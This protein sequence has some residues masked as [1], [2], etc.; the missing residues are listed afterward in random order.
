MWEL[1]CGNK[2]YQFLLIALALRLRLKFFSAMQ[3]IIEDFKQR[4]SIN[5]L[6]QGFRQPVIN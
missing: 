6:F 4:N 5:E 3:P 2:F 1:K